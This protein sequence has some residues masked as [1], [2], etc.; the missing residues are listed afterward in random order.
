MIKTS[1][2]K[3]KT[4]A[5]ERLKFY[6]YL[7][8]IVLNLQSHKWLLATVWTVMVV[9]ISCACRNIYSTDIL[10]NCNIIYTVLHFV[11]FS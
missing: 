5:T 3:K 6:F 7:I 1:A 4:S 2:K 11:F 10:H 9:E 8:L